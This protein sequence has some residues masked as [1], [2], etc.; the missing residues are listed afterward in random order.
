VLVASRVLRRIRNLLRRKPLLTLP[1]LSY[2]RLAE[3]LA[4]L[5][6]NFMGVVCFSLIFIKYQESAISMIPK[7][8]STLN[9]IAAFAQDSL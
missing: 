4:S 5:N 9:M 3:K 8:K 7:P 6:K 2:A 1:R